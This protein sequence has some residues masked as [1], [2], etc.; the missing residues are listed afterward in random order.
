MG[1]ARE[2][3]QLLYCHDCVIVPQWGGFLT[4]YKSARLDE[5]RK[6]VHPPGK[7]LSFNRNLVRNDGVLAD[8]IA[9]CEGISFDR[10]TAKI[11]TEVANWRS[12]MDQHGR[13]EVPHI[14]IFY[15]DSDR[16][17]QFD[18]DKRVNFLKDAYG[19]RPVPAI[20]LEQKAPVVRT[21]D[22]VV[23]VAE[24]VERPTSIFWA[25]AA[26][27][28]LLLSA[29]AVWY[30]TSGQGQRAEWANFAPLGKPAIT[31]SA[32]TI[33]VPDIAELP[34][35]TLPNDQ[36]GVQ[37]IPITT[38]DET[39]VTVDLGMPSPPEKEIA[40]T[41]KIAVEKSVAD[42]PAPKV[43]VPLMNKRFHLIGGCFA[44][45]ENADKLLEQLRNSGYA[46]LR[47]E[48]HKGLHPV[49]FGSYATRAEAVKALDALRTDPSRSAWLL[50]R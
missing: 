44:Q 27:V 14:G 6:L 35:F 3:H 10:A 33:A 16:N 38:D 20:L 39:M 11:A 40:P 45:P 2:L 8:H 13:V 42:I 21:L 46:A 41:P 30:F 17:L 43:E 50:I 47:L 9:K 4:Q 23:S 7:D 25:A 19:L 18:P 15:R 31:Y 36:L 34:V 48:E 29:S 22:P 28:A 24:P 37:K 49:A 5:G 1:I 12:E 32:V 26:S